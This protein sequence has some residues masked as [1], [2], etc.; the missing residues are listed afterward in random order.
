MRTSLLEPLTLRRRSP[1]DYGGGR[2]IRPGGCHPLGPVLAYLTPRGAATDSLK[3]TTRRSRALE[4][5][6]RERQL[7]ELE[8][9]RA[10]VDE[11]RASLTRLVH[12]GDAERR[13]IEGDFH[14]GVQQNLVAL[15]VKLQLAGPMVDADPAAARALLV[16]MERDVQEALDNAAGLAQRIHPQLEAG[17]LAAA[18]RF[19][20]VAEGT[21]ASVDVT[22]DSTYAPEILRTIY[23]CWLEVLRYARGE[24]RATAT[25]RDEHGAL[26]FEFAAA[27][28]EGESSLNGLRDRVEAL[29]GRLTVESDPERGTHVYG[30]LPGSG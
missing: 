21:P 9:L 25:V 3:P 12:A 6:Q 11:L 2:Q 13:A 10:E 22:A 30:S 7:D 26:T 19:A 27:I 5:E 15:A 23:L 18:L 8:R 17:S 14:D 4:A 28:T 20:A 24:A 16:E 1:P 29:G